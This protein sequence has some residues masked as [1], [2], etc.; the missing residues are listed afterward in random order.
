MGN[1]PNK[2]HNGHANAQTS[3]KTDAKTG[4]AGPDAAAQQQHPIGH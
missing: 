2:L 4:T 1:I 3:N